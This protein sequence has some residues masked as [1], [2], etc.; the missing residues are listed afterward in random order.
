MTEIYLSLLSGYEINEV[1]Q[2]DEAG[3]DADADA[4]AEVRCEWTLKKTELETK[5][6]YQ[7]Y[8]SYNYMVAC[9]SQIK[10]CEGGR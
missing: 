1:L 5:P 7:N 10:F 2:N 6:K 8:Q 9:Q 4:D 3:V